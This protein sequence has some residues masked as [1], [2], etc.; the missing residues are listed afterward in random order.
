M[1][2]RTR[3]LPYE[4]VMALPRPGHQDPLRPHMLFRSLIR[5]LSIPSLLATRFSFRTEGMEK[6]GDQPCLI[7]MNHSSFIDLKI[8]SQIFFP[9][10]FCIVSTT[11]SYVGKKWLMRLI[12][13]I[14]TQKFVT[15]MTLIRDMRYALHQLKTSVLMFPEA[16]YSLDGRATV[17]PRHLGVLLKRM[18]VPVVTVT[19]YGAYARD[20]L[21]NGLQLRKV[22]VTA[23]VRC[24]L[25]PEEIQEKS[26][27]ELDAMIG[28]AFSF[29]QYAWQRD[30]RVSIAEGFRAD[31]LHRMLY[32][33]P[34]CGAEGHMEG[35]GIHLTCHHCGK[36]Y[37]MDEYGQLRALTGETEFAHIPDWF[38]WQR[39]QVRQAIQDGTYGL[40][41]EVEIGMMVDHRAL[42]MVGEGR[43]RHDKDGFVLTG[44][45][46]KLRYEQSP[47]AS[48]SLNVDYFWYEIGDIISIGNGDAL[49]YCF[50]KCKDVVTRTR[51]AAE[52]LYE[53]NKA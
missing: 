48:H 17:L 52:I 42:Y 51:L 11:D 21:Y 41:T 13:C 14:P 28:E 44:C 39:Q 22:R 33:C 6:I 5:L 43:L 30:N 25:T 12:G 19:T 45:G 34:C 15:D 37:E 18:R 27:A 38:D 1:K 24:I 29:D 20:P 35:K 50:P 23:D 9:K 36:R 47:L 49:Y 8:A 32:Q 4:Q 31:G 3:K 26:L 46:G 10:P 2:I 16:G 53:M 7:L 40:D